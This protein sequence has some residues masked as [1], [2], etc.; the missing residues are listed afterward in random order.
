MAGYIAVQISINDP[1]T[2]ERYKLLAPPSIAKYGGKYLI[3]G[4]KTEILEGSW[5]PTRFVVL[6]FPS[7]EHAKKW[8]DS[9]EYAEAKALRQSCADTQMVLLE[10]AA[11]PAG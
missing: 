3:R 4:G 10:G 2:Y 9:P 5:S 11:S 6:E 8:W 1:R 7:V